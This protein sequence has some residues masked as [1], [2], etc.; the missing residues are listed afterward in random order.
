ME[1]IYTKLSNKAHFAP[2]HV[3]LYTLPGVPSIY[4][5]S[6]FGIEGR[7]ER[8]SDNSLRPAL[9]Y[10]DYADALETNPLTRLIAALGKVRK[11]CRA[12]SYGDYQELVLTNRQYAFARTAGNETALVTVN[13]DNNSASLTLP[14][15]GYSAYVGP[16]GRTGD[17]KRRK[18][19]CGAARL[20]WGN[21][22]TAAGG[23]RAC[24]SVGNCR[25]CFGNCTR[26]GDR[27]QGGR[28]DYGLQCR[29]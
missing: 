4:Y 21:L 25:A 23:K 19:H 9:R 22:A 16:V 11:Q 8:H 12:L 17:G 27:R 5:G 6:E 3:L 29:G 14:A 28:P 18:H 26:R 24:A 20:L 2:V 10:E 13:N 7:K 1:R 15:R